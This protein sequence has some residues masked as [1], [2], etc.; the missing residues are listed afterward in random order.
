ME[1]NC[2]GRSHFL[3]G[4]YQLCHSFLESNR[5]Y[6]TLKFKECEELKYFREIDCNM[7]MNAE[8]ISTDCGNINLKTLRR[9]IYII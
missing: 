2:V 5:T 7:Q 6:R 8:S 4:F 9:Q 3:V 1:K